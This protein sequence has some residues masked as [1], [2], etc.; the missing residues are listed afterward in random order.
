MKRTTAQFRRS[1]SLGI[2][3]TITNLVVYWGETK[4][5]ITERH[6]CWFGAGAEMLDAAVIPLAA[7]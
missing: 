5:R 7:I 4:L 1:G 3:S 2:R 6:T